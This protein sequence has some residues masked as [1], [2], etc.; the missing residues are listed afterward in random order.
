MKESSRKGC[1]SFSIPEEHKRRILCAGDP[2]ILLIRLCKPHL[3]ELLASYLSTQAF[4]SHRTVEA[5]FLFH[6]AREPNPEQTQRFPDPFNDALKNKGAGL[7]YYCIVDDSGAL[8][9]VRW[10]HSRYVSPG[11]HQLICRLT[12]TNLPLILAKLIPTESVEETGADFPDRPLLKNLLGPATGTYQ[13]HCSHHIQSESLL[14]SYH[15]HSPGSYLYSRLQ[16][17]GSAHRDKH[18]YSLQRQV[19]AKT[20]GID[21]IEPMQ[22]SALIAEIESLPPDHCLVDEGNFRVYT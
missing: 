7:I 4:P 22:Q 16:L 15:G 11:L 10:K 12:E 13:L 14:Q 21:V 2:C 5:S 1:I 20:S 19:K 9:S 8:G 17:L 3:T 6:S 18:L